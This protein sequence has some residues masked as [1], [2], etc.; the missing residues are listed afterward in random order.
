LPS[1]GT[2]STLTGHCPN[3]GSENF[4]AGWLGAPIKTEAVPAHNAQAKERRLDPA[5][6]GTNQPD[7]SEKAY[8]KLGRFG[9]I[10]IRAQEEACSARWADTPK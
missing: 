3:S 1:R 4:G 7:E 10:D 2:T 6:T 9:L 5:T 8:Q